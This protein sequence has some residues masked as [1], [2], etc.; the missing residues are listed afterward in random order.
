MRKRGPRRKRT[1][2]NAVCHC[3]SGKMPGIMRPKGFGHRRQNGWCCGECYNDRN[4]CP[5]LSDTD[6][7]EDLQDSSSG[8]R[9]QK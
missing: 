2:K 8:R 1:M 5:G 3:G 9:K 4:R 6:E 7:V